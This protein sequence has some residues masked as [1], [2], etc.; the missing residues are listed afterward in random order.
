VSWV[1]VAGLAGVLALA[2]VAVDVRR[3][4]ARRRAAWAA[5][6]RGRRTA[7][8]SDLEVNSQLFVRPGR[9][10]VENV[11]PMRPRGQRVGGELEGARGRWPRRT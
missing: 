3:Q 1:E 8:L 10:R 6:R 5:L 11:T 7:G 4:L 9:G 2:L